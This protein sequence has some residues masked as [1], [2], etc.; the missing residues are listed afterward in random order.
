MTPATFDPLFP[1]GTTFDSIVL[2]ISYFSTNQDTD[3]DRD[4]TFKLD[5]VF[6]DS[7]MKLSVF[8]S[9]Y[10][11]RDFQVDGEFNEGLGYF[12]DNTTSE[13]S[14]INSVDLEG[15]LLYEDVSFVPDAR[16][17]KF[18]DEDDELVSRANPAIRVKL[19]T[20]TEDDPIVDVTV[21]KDLCHQW[22][23]QLIH[24]CHQLLDQNAPA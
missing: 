17:I 5:S 9:N 4:S 13:N 14:P 18:F 19:N 2:N 24:R 21:Y 7:P 15:D 23:K 12:S 22:N 3:D 11:L 20:D 1:C 16:Q 6:G 8:R 10:F